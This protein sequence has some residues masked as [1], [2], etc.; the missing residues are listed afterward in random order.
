VTV[1]NDDPAFLELMDEVLELL[2]HDACVLSAAEI[3]SLESVVDTSPEVLVLDLHMNGDAEVGWRYITAARAHPAL[4]QVPLV[5]STGDHAFLRSREQELGAMNHMH[6]LA[7]PFSIEDVERLLRLLA[8]GIGA[9]AATLVYDGG[10]RHGQVDTL[11]VEPAVI[12]TGE[13]GG[14]YQHTPEVRDGLRVYRWQPLTE[15]E[16]QAVVRGDLRANQ[17]PP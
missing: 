13:E 6:V 12:G 11:D 15:A 10:P 7:K 5:L 16:A 14:V 3:T 1:V 4:A 17:D 9:Q 8:P 2:G